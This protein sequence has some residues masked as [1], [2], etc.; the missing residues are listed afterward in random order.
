MTAFSDSLPWILV[1]ILTIIAGDLLFT[2]FS[3][4]KNYEELKQENTK[5][6]LL[7]DSI[8]EGVY[9]LD[10]DGNCTFCNAATLRLL[11]Y[12][13]KEDLVGR[14]LHDL[15]HHTR[16]DGSAYPAEECKACLAYR[17]N[18]KVHLEDEVLWRSDG[19]GFQAEYWSY[20]VQKG[21]R[22]V[23]A[24]VSFIDIS[25]RK[26]IEERLR[27]ANRELD[28]FVYTVSHDLR[29]PISAIVGYSDLIMET[30]R[31]DLNQEVIGLLET[32]ESQGQKMAVLVEDLLAL[33]RAGN[34]QQPA[35]AV[36]A[37]AELSFVL[38]ELQV[39][40]DS[41]GAEVVAGDLPAVR[42][43]GILLVQIFQN[44][45]DNALRYAGREGSPIEVGGVRSGD[46]V[47]FY[48]S[49]HGQG[50][51]EEER[52]RIFDVF[53]RGSTGR[54]IIGSGVG[55]ATVQKIAR[56]YGGDAWIEE[57]PGGGATFWVRM[58]GV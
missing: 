36:D 47:R 23:G 52:G 57:T 18:Q 27:E 29:T 26:E 37:N 5:R 17:Q 42:I 54:G 6:D 31:T 20:P 4:K 21:T 35:E 32:I 34:L 13:N 43:P 28:A 1:V 14:N 2:Y 46:G 45:L 25:E 12:R 33:A 40:I 51:P 41:T 7:L 49:D 39:K 24:V 22:L 9:G 11:G 56:L 30:Y 3:L 38:E 55:L 44:L 48:V 15:I 19:T 50:I 8:A 53:Y 10:L 58:V 16:A